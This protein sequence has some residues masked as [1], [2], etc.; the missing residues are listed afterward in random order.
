MT[1][2]QYRE[3]LGWSRAELARAAKLDYGTVARAEKGTHITGRAARALAEALSNELGQ[4]L[5]FQ[6][7]SEL[8]VKV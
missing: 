6:Q 5:T 1:L 2:E 3:Q 8:K 4:K 7:I